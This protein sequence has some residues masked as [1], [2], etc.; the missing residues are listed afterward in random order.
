MSLTPQLRA[1]LQRDA[2]IANTSRKRWSLQSLAELAPAVPHKNHN[3]NNSM[4]TA[5]RTLLQCTVERL[6][7]QHEFLQFWQQQQQQQPF[8]DAT[9]RTNH[10]LDKRKKWFDTLRYVHADTYQLGR[11]LLDNTAFWERFAA[12][13]QHTVNAIMKELRARHATTLETVV[14]LVLTGTGNG[15]TNDEQQAQYEQNHRSAQLFLQ[16]RVGI[17]LFCDHHVELYRQQ[18][19]TIT[20][21]TKTTTTTNTDSKHRGVITIQAPLG[22]ILVDAVAEAQHIVDA[23][24]QIYPETRYYYN[25]DTTGDATTTTTTAPSLLVNDTASSNSFCQCTVV[26]PWLHHAL[27]ELLKNAMAS[28]VQR[29]QLDHK[30]I[31]APLDIIV[32]APP[33]TTSTTT[34]A[35]PRSLVL[36]IVDRGTGIA[37]GDG[38]LAR[39]MALGHSSVDRRWDRLDEQ[40]S[41]ASVRSPLSSLGVGLPVS[42]ILMEHF[43]GRLTLRNNNDD[44]SD[45]ENSTG[46]TARIEWPLDDTILERV[47]GEAVL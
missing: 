40:Q 41:Y 43:G 3:H 37:P 33:P 46:C 5:S 45:K 13:E 34:T 19:Q 16:R 29:M 15:N 18:Q 30:S 12:P 10:V 39:A 31:P 23:H 11:R 27:V 22:P 6:A 44:S 20:A 21:T 36:E 17:Q 7:E 25:C 35:T 42:R 2:T 32:T 28:T 14:D 9:Q 24:L 1:A 4:T 26:R 38:N 8:P 47:P